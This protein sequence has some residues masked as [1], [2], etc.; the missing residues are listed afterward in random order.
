MVSLLYEAGKGLGKSKKSLKK[1]KEAEGVTKAPDNKMQATFQA[2]LEK[3]KEAAE[4]AKGA[5]TTAANKMF[6]FYAIL[7]SV[8]AKYAWNKIVEE[9]TECNLYVDLQGV[10][11][12]GPRGMSCQLFD[13]CVLFHLLTIFPINVAEQEKYYITN[14]LKEPQRVNV[15]QF[16][17]HVEQLNAYIVQMP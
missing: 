6:T 12:K 4:K 10:L 5:M 7:L 15:C 14:V 2:D 1:A 17:R 9:Q 11:Q 16:V 3:A 13:N 8:K